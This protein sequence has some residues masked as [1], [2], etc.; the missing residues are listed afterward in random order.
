MR[1]IDDQ[2]TM[3]SHPRLGHAVTNERSIFNSSAGMFL[4]YASEESRCRNRR[5]KPDA[6]IMASQG[7]QQFSGFS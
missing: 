6:E 7:A 4:K 2:C 1:E 5:S 3:P